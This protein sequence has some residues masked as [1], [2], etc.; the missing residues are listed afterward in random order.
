MSSSICSKSARSWSNVSAQRWASLSASINW[1][2]TRTPS[3]G[4]LHRSFQ[5]ITHP[6]VPADLLHVS[7]L[8]LVS[9]GGVARDHEAAGNAREVGGQLVGEHVGEIILSGIAGEIGEGQHH[10]REA[11]GRG[12]PGPFRDEDIPAASGDHDE[13]RDH[14]PD[15][16]SQRRPFAGA[17]GVAG[18][19]GFAWAG[20]PTCSE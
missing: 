1:A 15:E 5:R 8:A 6:E 12:W 13:R 17:V 20:T 16:G 4:R 7:R 2:L 18:C 11:R 19:A 3:A 10:D 14:R 9:E